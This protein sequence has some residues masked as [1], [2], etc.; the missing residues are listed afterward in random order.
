[1]AKMIITIKDF[2]I[3]VIDQPD[4]LEIEFRDYGIGEDDWSD[5]DPSCKEDAQGKHYQ[6]IIFSATV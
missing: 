4:D 5:D 2:D 6:E 3:G 1:M